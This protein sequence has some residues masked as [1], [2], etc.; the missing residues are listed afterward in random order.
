MKGNDRNKRYGLLKKL[1]QNT[2]TDYLRRF[3]EDFDTVSELEQELKG[4]ITSILYYYKNVRVN[5]IQMEIPK[6]LAPIIYT[7]HGIYLEKVRHVKNSRYKTSF[8]VVKRHVYSLDTALVYYLLTQEK[9]V[10][11]K[12]VE[13]LT[14]TD[15]DNQDNQ[16]N[17]DE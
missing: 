13:T 15:T 8:G 2:E 12:T 6:H 4:L 14:H 3:A 11:K 16:D 1:L 5:K 9:Q 7:L 17:Q 10:H